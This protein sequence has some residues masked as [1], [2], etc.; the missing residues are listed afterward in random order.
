MASVDRVRPAIRIKQKAIATM[1][2]LEV[3]HL[4]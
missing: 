3:N 2:Q 4:K 1:R